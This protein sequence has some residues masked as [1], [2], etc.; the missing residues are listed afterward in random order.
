MAEALRAQFWPMLFFI[1]LLSPSCHSFTWEGC[2]TACESKFCSGVDSYIVAPLL[3]YGKYCGIFYSG[4]PGEDPCDGLDRCC[5][6]HDHC[7]SN[8]NY[9][10]VTC[11][12][13]LL[14]CVQAYQNSGDGQFSG[15]TCDIGDVENIINV[16]IEAGVWIGDGIGDGPAP[17]PSDLPFSSNSNP[18]YSP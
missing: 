10:N 7:I 2:S 15:N 4:C 5:M 6:T 13:D 11:N 18:N 17:P 8:S 14:D 16:A 9:L 3:R 12:Q 1:V